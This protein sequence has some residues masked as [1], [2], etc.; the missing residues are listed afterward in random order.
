LIFLV[1]PSALNVGDAV[2]V[3]WRKVLGDRI[4]PHYGRSVTFDVLSK[5]AIRAITAARHPENFH[6]RYN[7]IELERCAF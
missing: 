6:S 4:A 5:L 1:E 7:R 3:D 2:S